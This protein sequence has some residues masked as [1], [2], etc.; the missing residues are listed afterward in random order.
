MR[1]ISAGIFSYERW[2]SN[3]AVQNNFYPTGEFLP[4]LTHI[5]NIPTISSGRYMVLTKELVSQLLT[6]KKIPMTK[7]TAQQKVTVETLKE[8][9]FVI[10]LY[11]KQT[12]LYFLTRLNQGLLNLCGSQT[13]QWSITQSFNYLMK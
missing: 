3:F 7:L 1:I 13:D 4:Y 9:Y 2:S 6:E 8:G 12:S 10:L 5:A 11:V